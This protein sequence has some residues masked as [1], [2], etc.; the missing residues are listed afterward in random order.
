M[1]PGLG[2]AFDTNKHDTTNGVPERS[3]TGYLHLA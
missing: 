3:S 1:L 2:F